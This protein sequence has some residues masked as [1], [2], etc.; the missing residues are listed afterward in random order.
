MIG[1]IIPVLLYAGALFLFSYVLKQDYQKVFLL[2]FAQNKTPPI[3]GER[4]SL[5]PMY[6]LHLFHEEPQN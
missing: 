5:G 2:Y 6:K 1:I 3:L 4:R